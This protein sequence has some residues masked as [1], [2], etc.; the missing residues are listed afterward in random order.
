MKQITQFV[1]VTE[2]QYLGHIAASKEDEHGYRIK[3]LEVTEPEFTQVKVYKAQGIDPYVSML[4]NHEK[5][6]LIAFALLLETHS[7]YFILTTA[8]RG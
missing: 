8:V 6:I 5:W 2:G 1:E 3:S 7:Q 4:D